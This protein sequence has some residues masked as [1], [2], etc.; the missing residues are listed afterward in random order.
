LLR[1]LA[2]RLRAAG[3]PVVDSTPLLAA[4]AAERLPR[5]EYLYWRDD[6]HWNAAGIR[7]AAEAVWGEVQSAGAWQP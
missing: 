4:Q 2:D 7:L 5:H 1:A 6:T 3:V